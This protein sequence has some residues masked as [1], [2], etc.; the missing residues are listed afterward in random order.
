[1]GITSPLLLEHSA[2]NCLQA[3]ANLGP[4]V[5]PG[6]GRRRPGRCGKCFPCRF[7][8]FLSQFFC[9]GAVGMENLRLPVTPLEVTHTRAPK[10]AIGLLVYFAWRPTFA[11][12]Q[13]QARLWVNQYR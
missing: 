5:R 10:C 3:Q 8:C 9:C 2:L 4:S 7:R 13:L 6:T 1:M 11:Y 12:S